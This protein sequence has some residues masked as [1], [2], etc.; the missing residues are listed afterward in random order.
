[1]TTSTKSQQNEEIVLPPTLAKSV[2]KNLAQLNVL[3]AIAMEALKMS[4]DPECSMGE[5]SRL[6]ERDVK[7]ATDILRMAN[8]VVFSGGT[9]VQSLHQAVVR[10][11]FRHCKN[12]IL[13]SSVS[14]LMKK[15]SL[16]ESWVRELLWRHSF[17]TGMLSVHLNRVFNAGFFGEEFTA[18]LVHDFGRTL[19]AFCLPKDFAKIDPLE[20]NESI[21][22]LAY[23]Q[24][25]AGIDHAQLG[26]WFA[27]N[28]QLPES[29]YE[30]IRYHHQ[31]ELATQSRRL[32]AIVAI[33]DQIA[34]SLQRSDD[35]S[36]FDPETIPFFDVLESTGIS[37]PQKK[38]I[39][40]YESIINH[41]VQDASEMTR[42]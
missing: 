19:F 35:A 9:S 32:V 4:K 8:S 22:T 41:A 36:S 37:Q 14:G 25:V 7:L 15:L 13:S 23:E 34:N 26:A 39:E 3:P 40:N 21:E 20:F 33:G 24:E 1:M 6:V 10:L 30:V 17:L 18:G 5:F 31:P 16:E 38:F 12:L 29:I 2:E 28:N 11:G 42:E 27:K